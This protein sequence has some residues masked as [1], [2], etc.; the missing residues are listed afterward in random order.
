MRPAVCAKLY[1]LKEIF[2]IDKHKLVA[3]LH[4]WN[5]GTMDTVNR[6]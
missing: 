3:I 1:N 2:V 4:K 6:Y 5:S